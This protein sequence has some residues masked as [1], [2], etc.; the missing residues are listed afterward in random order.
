MNE[1]RLFPRLRLRAIHA[2]RA[3]GHFCLAEKNREIVS[4]AVQRVLFP[5]LHVIVC[6]KEHDREGPSLEL[7]RAEVVENGEEAQH[8]PVHLEELLHVGV[9]VAPAEHDLPID[10]LVG[11][12]RRRLLHFDR[13]L[14]AA[15]GVHL[16]VDRCHLLLAKLGIILASERVAVGQTDRS[17]IDLQVATDLQVLGCDVAA[18]R[19]RKPMSANQC[20]LRNA[21]VVLARLC[22]MGGIILKV[23][24]DDDP[25]Y[26]VVFKVR[27]HNSLFEVAVEPQH[28]PVQGIPGRQLAEVGVTACILEYGTSGAVWQ[29]PLAPL[30]LCLHGAHKLRPV[31]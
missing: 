16:H 13:L 19:S 15:E 18:A 17:A 9:D 25:A 6:H 5:N 28:V 1:L 8:L 26:S 22:D 14:G 7:R 31:V 10:L 24:K 12:R 23:I 11:S 27:L 30:L 4:A 21:A 2:H 20:T 3:L 29:A